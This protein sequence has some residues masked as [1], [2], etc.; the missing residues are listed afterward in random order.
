[1]KVKAQVPVGHEVGRQCALDKLERTVLFQSFEAHGFPEFTHKE[2]K[3]LPV[4]NV[5]VGVLQC[6][7]TLT[8]IHHEA[9]VIVLGDRALEVRAQT[10][11]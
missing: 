9:K 11:N 3:F 8:E 1:M 2:L 7:S 4:M 5:G 6:G 10:A